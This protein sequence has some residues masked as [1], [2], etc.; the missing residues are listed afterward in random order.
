MTCKK[1]HCQRH[2]R[3]L[4]LKLELSLQ[5]KEMKIPVPAVFHSS[6]SIIVLV[7][8]YLNDNHHFPN[9]VAQQRSDTVAN[10]Q[11]ISFNKVC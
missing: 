8:Y 1:E 5:L 9:A 2:N 7:H 3:L 6:L 10:S 11:T 4:C